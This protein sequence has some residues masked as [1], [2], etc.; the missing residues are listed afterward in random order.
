MI[1][2]G[3]GGRA[4]SVTARLLAAGLASLFLLG[5]AGCED[6]GPI[7]EAAEETGDA[8]EEAGDEIEGATDEIDEEFD[9]Q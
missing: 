5:A 3:S 6:E 1:R 8:I 2:P 7:E 4:A 9:T